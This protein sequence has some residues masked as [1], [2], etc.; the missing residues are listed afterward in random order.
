NKP[1]MEIRIAGFVTELKLDA[2]FF[3]VH[4]ANIMEIKKNDLLI[5]PSISYDDN[6]IKEN[7][8][9]ITWIR[10]QY[11][12]GAE[13]A[14]MCSGAFLLAATGLLEGK[15]C[16]THWNLA[17]NF[18]RLFPNIDLQPDKLITAEKG[19]IGRAHV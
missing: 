18:R 12:A 9:L 3:S 1:M 7:A 8:A 17:D 10:E 13:I 5:I 6:L 11:K 15:T 16:S 14:T 2:G 19:K 4:P